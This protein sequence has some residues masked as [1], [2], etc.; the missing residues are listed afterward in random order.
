MGDSARLRDEEEKRK[1]PLV[2]FPVSDKAAIFSEYGF[3]LVWTP[4]IAQSCHHFLQHPSL[5]LQLDMRDVTFSCC[6]I[7]N[8][9]C[10]NK[11]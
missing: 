4:A 11:T 3:T 10:L 6:L 2:T 1:R 7:R 9:R 8:K 5:L